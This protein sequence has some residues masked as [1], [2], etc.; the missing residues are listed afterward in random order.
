MTIELSREQAERLRNASEYLRRDL[1]ENTPDNW[2]MACA[3]LT[4]AEAV[5]DKALQCEIECET[6]YK[7]T[8]TLHVATDR[9]EEAETL[10]DELSGRCAREAVCDRYQAEPGE[11]EA[12]IVYY[13]EPADE[14]ERDTVTAK[15]QQIAAR[16]S[17]SMAAIKE[18]LEYLRGEIN[19]E[20]ISAAELCDLQW[21]AEYIEPG[22]VQLLQAAGVPEFPEDEA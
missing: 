16:C 21:L 14:H 18:R 1:Q 19:A 5:L 11:P 2:R 15:V 12:M 3:Y 8:L 13:F 10:L 4:S 9:A 22:D 6:A 17:L 7:V 20:R